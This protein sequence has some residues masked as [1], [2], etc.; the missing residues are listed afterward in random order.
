MKTGL[1]H[2][3]LKSVLVLPPQIFGPFGPSSLV[4]PKCLVQALW[5]YQNVFGPPTAGSV[6][7]DFKDRALSLHHS[8]V[9]VFKAMT[10]YTLDWCP[11]SWGLSLILLIQK[12]EEYW[13]ICLSCLE[14]NW[15]FNY[16]SIKISTAN[17]CVKASL[18]FHLSIAWF[19]CLLHFLGCVELMS[20]LVVCTSST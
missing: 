9:S 2:R 20:S 12:Y 17:G 3:S 10:P 14:Q 16:V 8:V 6:V 5:S 15:L 18:R 1:W 13:Y 11:D 4:L 7:V 19:Y